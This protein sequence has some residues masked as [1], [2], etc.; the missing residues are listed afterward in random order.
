MEFKG[1]CGYAAIALVICFAHITVGLPNPRV[2]NIDTTEEQL[3]ISEQAVT[4][5]PEDQK[6]AEKTHYNG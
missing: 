2:A 5:L 1:V 6:S 4:K 3:Q